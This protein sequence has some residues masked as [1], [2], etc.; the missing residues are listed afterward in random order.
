MNNT[1]KFIIVIGLTLGYSVS[2]FFLEGGYD[3]LV[4]YL[5][6]PFPE[7]TT[8]AWVYLFTYPL[9][10]LGWPLGWSVLIFISVSVIGIAAIIWGNKNWWIPLLS[11]PLI[12][13]IWLGQIEFL[14]VLG[15]L[16]TGLF[17]QR[18]I[19]SFWLGLSWLVLITKP[20]VGLGILIFQFLMVLRN[21]L[22]LKDLISPLLLFCSMI[23]LTIV[24]WP[25]WINDW[26]RTLQTFRPDMGW[27]DASIWP[28]G[29]L[30]LPV[31][32]YFSRDQEP[33]KKI[34]MLSSASLLAS[35]YFALYHCTTLMTV[36]DNLLVFILSWVILF[37]G[38]GIPDQWV[39]WGWIVPLSVLLIDLYQNYWQSRIAHPEHQE[40]PIE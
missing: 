20:H 36:T 11:T 18:K 7:T 3:A 37:I 25:N 31:A 40:K 21:E 10:F 32:I 28:Y 27:W 30:A 15:L 29:L 5:K 4:F 2:V 17:I 35:P 9:S 16:I 26:I 6:A 38:K 14:P 13:N 12:W 1:K 33:L 22:K 8:P 39:K 24:F 19:P 34:R 23:L